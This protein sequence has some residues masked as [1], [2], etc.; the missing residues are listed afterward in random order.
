MMNLALWKISEKRNAKIERCGKYD[1]RY[2][3]CNGELGN[4]IWFDTKSFLL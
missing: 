4:G 2:I 3:C 1:F